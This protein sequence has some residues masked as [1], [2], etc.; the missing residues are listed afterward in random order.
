MI[1]LLLTA[2]MGAAMLMAVLMRRRSPVLALAFALVSF[3]GTWFAW[4]PE[5]L[6]TLARAVGV[7]R[8]A[9]L[10]VYL[11]LSLSFLALGALLLQLRHL[12]NRFTILARE[13]ALIQE[14]REWGN[15]KSRNKIDHD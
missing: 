12:Q 8:G 7:G 15:E 14:R 4:W 6:N 9:D 13:L 3:L 5:H 10:A 11:G 2:L 1:S